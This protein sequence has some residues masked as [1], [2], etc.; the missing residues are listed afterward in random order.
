MT[1][2]LAIIPFALL[3][4]IV[5]LS[6]AFGHNPTEIKQFAEINSGDTAWMLT[7]A[8]LVL[9]MTPGLAFFYGGMV[10]KKNVISTMLQSF[11]CM[12]IVSIIW[13]VFG[14][15][16]AFGDSIGGFIGNP[17]TFFLMNGVL[18]HKPWA[19]APTVPLV[20]F[21]F[22]QLKFAIITPALVTGAF[23]ERIRFTS[24]IF[25][26]C[27][28]IIFIYCPLAHAT[29]HPDGFL[30]KLGV[31]DFA[32]G[33]VVH[34]SAGLAA[35]AGA[36]YLKKRTDTGENK[37]ARITYVLLGT[38]LLWFGWF[39]FNGGSAM[40][41][42]ALAASALATTAVASGA[43]AFAWVI[44]DALRGKKP[45]AMGTSI[46]AV[47]GLV[48]I[49]PA[50][51]FVSLPHALVIGVVAAI[52]SNMMVEWR[53]KTG[54]DDTLDVFPCHGVGG[55]VGMLLTGV[56]ANKAINTANATGNG[57]F[58]GETKLFTTHVL[59]LLGVIVF[60]LA[61][62]FILLKITDLITPLRASEDEELEGLDR[63]QHGESL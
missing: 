3:I 50:A 44:F 36:I 39:G 58:F 63:S 13:V 24:Y 4:L 41:A 51:G 5:I 15:S 61:A 57:L 38:G 29:W 8:A 42:N 62:S 19:L 46:G 33:T 14:F 23:S 49:T 35:L 7:S 21:A 31:L 18:E 59:V 28:F 53:T 22:F 27:L 20:V 10:K 1:R 12:A 56:F 60:V 34:M 37:P 11:I 6:L 16:L 48:A 43:A 47:V 9:I 25:F 26:I 17:G 2:K 52:I 45:S 54:I 40:A 32:G 30:A 55:M